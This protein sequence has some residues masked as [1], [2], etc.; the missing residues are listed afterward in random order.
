MVDRFWS[1]VDVRG[2]DECWPWLK[3]VMS[4]GY[5]QFYLDG[6]PKLAHRVAFVLAGGVIPEDY[7]VDHTCLFI[8][9]CNPR[10]L[11]AVPKPVNIERY[12]QSVRSNPC[13]N[14]H[15]PSLRIT[16][17]SGRTECGECNR[18]RDRAR[19]AKRLLQRS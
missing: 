19:Y 6:G 8:L 3:S 9:C 4:S 10:H 5:G 1:K 15:D 12:Y 11:E 2:P 14:G 18:E 13:V 16:R 17:K 7:E